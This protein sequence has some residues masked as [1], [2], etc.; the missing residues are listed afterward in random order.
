MCGVPSEITWRTRRTH[1][2]PRSAAW[3]QAE[4]ATSPPIECPTSASD[5]TSTGHA[6]VSSSSRSASESPFSEMC[7]PLLYRTSTGAQP[8]SRRRRV[9]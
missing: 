7:R 2:S 3:Q 4:R 6:A 5:S 1:E 8:R 9:A